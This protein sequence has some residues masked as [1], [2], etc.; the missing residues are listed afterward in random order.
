[1][2]AMSSSPIKSSAISI[3]YTHLV[4]M[5]WTTKRFNRH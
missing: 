5:M 4:P 1:M 3:N 2:K